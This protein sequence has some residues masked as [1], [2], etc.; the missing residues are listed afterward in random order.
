MMLRSWLLDLLPLKQPPFRAAT[1]ADDRSRSRPRS[2]GRRLSL[3]RRERTVNVAAGYAASPAALNYE[4][5]A[6]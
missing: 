4:I 6:Q 5:F 1:G 2:E 3:E